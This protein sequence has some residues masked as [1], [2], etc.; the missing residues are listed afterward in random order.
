MPRGTADWQLLVRLGSKHGCKGN[1]TE[2]RA[3]DD[4]GRHGNGRAKAKITGRASFTRVDR[5]GHLRH[6][7]RAG[8]QVRARA[9]GGGLTSRRL[10]KRRAPPPRCTGTVDALLT[11]EVHAFLNTVYAW[12]VTTPRTCLVRDLCSEGTVGH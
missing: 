3:A 4:A 5:G 6:R 12:G 9:S 7:I 10:R 8:L 2:P 11:P 1:D